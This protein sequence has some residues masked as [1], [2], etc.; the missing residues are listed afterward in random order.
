MERSL[1]AHDWDAA[2][3]AAIHSGISAADALLAYHGGVRSAGQD[4]RVSVDLLQ[5]VLGEGATSA[6]KHLK[7]LL[8][9]KN[10]V[11]YEQRR[12]IESEAV[13]LAKHARRFVEWTRAQLPM[14]KTRG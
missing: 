8:D 4:H 12:L 11:E 5:E 2:G 3:S 1:E 6:S 13:E 14:K 7:R 10:L 9:K